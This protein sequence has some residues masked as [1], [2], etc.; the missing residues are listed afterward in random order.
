MT[1]SDS[2]LTYILALFSLIGGPIRPAGQQPIIGNSLAMEPVSLVRNCLHTC[3]AVRA[4]R[5]S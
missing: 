5:L 2:D 1:S 3:G 4:D